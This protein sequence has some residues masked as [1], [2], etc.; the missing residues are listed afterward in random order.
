MKK[1]LLFVGI[2]AVSLAGLIFGLVMLIGLG[3][4]SSDVYLEA[5]LRAN[6][7]ARVQALL[8]EPIEAGFMPTG[9]IETNNSSGKADLSVNLR[10]PK[11]EGVLRAVADKVDGEWRFQMLVVRGSDGERV[12][13][14]VE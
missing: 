10:G 4:K 12:N 7:D 1:A 9:S 6:K 3:L 13:V 11:G 2:G 8:G 14:L 5:V